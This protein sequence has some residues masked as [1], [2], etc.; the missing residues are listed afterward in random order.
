M[1]PESWGVVVIGL[2]NAVNKDAFM[3]HNNDRPWF[4]DCTL[5]RRGTR[6]IRLSCRGGR[7]QTKTKG[8]PITVKAVS[9]M[10]HFPFH[11]CF[12]ICFQCEHMHLAGLPLTMFSTVCFLI[13]QVHSSLLRMEYTGVHGW[14]IY[15][16]SIFNTTYTFSQQNTLR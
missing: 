2:V 7:G 8:K 6:W 3:A 9:L 16:A 13:Y 10:H 12:H 11:I 1:N 4:L 15:T 5:C 14:W